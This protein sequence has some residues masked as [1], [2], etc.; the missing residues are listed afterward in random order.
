MLRFSA[1][2]GALTLIVYAST[3]LTLYL[4]QDRLLFPA[5]IH[6]LNT[7]P[8]GMQEISLRTADGLVL[9]SWFH[10]SSPN[11]P[12]IVY[13]HGNAGSLNWKGDR[14]EHFAQAGFGVLALEYRGYGGNPGHPS[15]A[16]LY[17]D[18][19]AAL[20]FLQ[21]KGVLPERIVL[22]GESLGTN[23]AVQTALHRA[24]AGVVLDSP[25]TSIADA[26]AYHYPYVPARLLIKNRFDTLTC[27]PNLT[28]P[29]LVIRTTE[30]RV[31][32]PAQ[33]L[34]VFEAAQQP[35]EVWTTD[36]ATHAT[37]LEH[38]GMPVVLDFVRR[39]TATN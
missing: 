10:E 24:V 4:R 1:A 19:I 15:E 30:D 36:H 5:S 21:E 14:L 34:A 25:Y 22:Y 16:G 27:I 32:P 38:G 35:K 9:K 6:P 29:L 31:V 12:V 7:P 26:A 28:R 37:V 3:V 11:A 39:V 13:F 17:R 18:A 20:D 23:V 8:S 2:F 33:S